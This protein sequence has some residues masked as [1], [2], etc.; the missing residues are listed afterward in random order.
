MFLGGGFGLHY[1]DY[2]VTVI[3]SGYEIYTTKYGASFG[4]SANAGFRIAVGS[5]KKNIETRFSYMKTVT[6]ARTS[7]FGLGALFN[8]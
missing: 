7:A 3:E 1:G 8:F 2:G 5:H 4:P 6:N